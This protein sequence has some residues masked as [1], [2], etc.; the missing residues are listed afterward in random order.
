MADTEDR[1]REWGPT[2]A[3]WTFW[4]TIIGAALFVSAVVAFIL[5]RPV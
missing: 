2:I 1:D 4:L 5:G 3:K